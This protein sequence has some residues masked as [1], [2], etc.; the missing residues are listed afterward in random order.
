M[1]ITPQLIDKTAREL[2]AQLS[3]IARTDMFGGAPKG[4]HPRDLLPACSSVIVLA[5]PFPKEALDSSPVIYTAVRDGMNVIMDRMAAALAEKLRGWGADALPIKCG[6]AVLSEG[7]YRGQLSLKHAAVLAGLGRLGK[8]TL[9]IN[10]RLGNM[11]W[12]NAVLTSVPLEPS[13]PAS[14][15]GCVEGCRLCLDACAVKALGGGAMRQSAC[16]EYAFKRE[17]GAQ[18]I[19]C[20]AC[21]EICPR[22]FGIRS[23]G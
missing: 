9:L 6:P 5:C 8:N 18:K 16:L 20:R 7:R 15:D 17:N 19:L 1:E 4:F 14:Y 2:G 21:R 3:G 22:R 12:L 10:D 23:G 11:L 13:A